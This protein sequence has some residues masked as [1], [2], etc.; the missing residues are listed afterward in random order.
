MRSFI[1]RYVS[2]LIC[3]FCLARTQ[4]SFAQKQLEGYWYTE[5]TG[6]DEFVV[7]MNAVKKADKYTVTIDNLNNKRDHQLQSSVVKLEKDSIKFEVPDIR[8]RFVGAFSADKKQIKTRWYQYAGYID[9]VFVKDS[10]TEGL[11]GG[12]TCVRQIPKQTQKNLYRIY[13][14]DNGA[15]G[16]VLYRLDDGAKKV[17]LKKVYLQHDSLFIVDQFNKVFYGVP[18]KKNDVYEGAIKLKSGNIPYTLSRVDPLTIKEFCPRTSVD[19]KPFTYSYHRPETAKDGWKTDS[20]TKEGSLTKVN[21]LMAAILKED[22]KQVHSIVVVKKGKLVLE[23]YFYGH[24]R[25]NYTDI[26]EATI[27]I[28]SALTGLAIDKHF[29]RNVN[30]KVY[31]YYSKLRP[32]TSVEEDSTKNK[33]T[34]ANLLTMS[35]GLAGSDMDM[36]SPGHRKKMYKSPDWFKFSLDLPSMETPGVNFV[37]YTGNAMLVGGIIE[38]AS[39]LTIPQFSEKYLFKPLG[40]KDYYWDYTPRGE[41]LTG[42]GFYITSRELARLGQLYLNNGKW[43]G[44]QI[45][46]S[47]WI[48]TSTGKQL[49]RTNG[50]YFGYFW[51]LETL[52]VDGKD[53]AVYFANG[54]GGNKLY[55]IPSL[56]AVV[57]VT[58]KIDTYK[59]ELSILSNYLLPALATM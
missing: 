53:V 18:G 25:G 23:E 55:V 41:A 12:W 45:L 56:D 35:S 15:L 54:S 19:G 34:I 51:W 16:G 14:V 40:I 10:A 21:E 11:E 44:K 52:K 3:F 46:S 6:N 59:E 49:Q 29:I 38:R 43:N 20:I 42:T 47:S 13:P 5:L 9:A 57:T 8:A 17:E 2:L 22:I 28:T 32:V 31:P 33:I 48:A 24:D 30:D 58:G 7:K 37:Y 1:P 27:S 4:Q 50:K 39:H 26:T 36:N